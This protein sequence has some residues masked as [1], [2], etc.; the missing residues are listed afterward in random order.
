M[1][2]KSPAHER[3]KLIAGLFLPDERTIYTDRRAP[4]KSEDMDMNKRAS[5][6]I[7]RG[8]RERV[9]SPEARENLSA[10]AA[11]LLKVDHG[12]IGATKHG[13]TQGLIGAVAAAGAHN[14]ADKQAFFD[15]S[16]A[17]LRKSIF[18]ASQEANTLESAR[19]GFLDGFAT[20]AAAT[21]THTKVKPVS[22]PQTPA[23]A[24]G[25]PKESGRAAAQR[26]LQK[27]LEASGLND[28]PAGT[29]RELQ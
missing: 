27:R 9:G 24:A 6:S 19:K 12:P 28:G 16:V 21:K 20:G 2:R 1:K 11:T 18:E 15:Q 8:I 26:Q 7:T 22:G 23:A 14:T 4:F 10:E 3:E 17:T 25:K 5:G 13:V 29:E